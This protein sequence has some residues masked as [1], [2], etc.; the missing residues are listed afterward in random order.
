M[1]SFA[2][3]IPIQFLSR[4]PIVSALS[5]DNFEQVIFSKEINHFYSKLALFLERNHAYSSRKVGHIRDEFWGSPGGIFSAKKSPHLGKFK[6]YARVEIWD[7][8]HW[9]PVITH[10]FSINSRTFSLISTLSGA[11]SAADIYPHNSPHTPRSI[12]LSDGLLR[13]RHFQ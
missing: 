12:S 5:G 4:H 8:S 11:T 2:V 7:I 1:A 3:S 10:D 9:K 6:R 13:L